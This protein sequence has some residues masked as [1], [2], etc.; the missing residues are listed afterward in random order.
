MK[1]LNVMRQIAKTCFLELYSL[2]ILNNELALLFS[3]SDALNS[4]VKE[5]RPSKT[6]CK[7]PTIYHL[8]TFY[9]DI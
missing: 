5:V 4:N 9:A 6:G 1:Q 3:H 7:F 8:S 2:L